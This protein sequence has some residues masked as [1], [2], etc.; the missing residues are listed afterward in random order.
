MTFLATKQ[1]P[2]HSRRNGNRGYRNELNSPEENQRCSFALA[3]ASRAQFKAQCNY[4]ICF[5]SY[6]TL[7]ATLNSVLFLL[8]IL[9]LYV[10]EFQLPL[11]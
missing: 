9:L 2:K 6:H 8:H 7:E 11:K 5:T 10:Y 4:W 1:L 3:S